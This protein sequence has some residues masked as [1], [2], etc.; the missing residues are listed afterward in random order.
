MNARYSFDWRGGEAYWQASTAHQG[1]RTNDLRDAQ[2]A[3]F[4][5]LGAYTTLDLSAGWRKNSWAIDVFLKNATNQRAELAR[6][7]ECAALTCGEESYTVFA[8]P[9]TLGVRFSKE[10]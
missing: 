1:D 3:V 8:Q 5:K 9:R 2:S 4:G 7:S 10:F 6:F